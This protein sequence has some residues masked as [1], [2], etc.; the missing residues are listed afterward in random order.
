[1]TTNTTR[2]HITGLNSVD[3]GRL[4]SNQF[5]E[6]PANAGEF[7]LEVTYAVRD[8]SFAVAY[9][10]EADALAALANLCGSEGGEFTSTHHADFTAPGCNY[11]GARV[12]AV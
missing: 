8:A 5:I 1:M 2:N 9:K 4:I 11:S 3:A 10:N 12:Y 7:V 6:E